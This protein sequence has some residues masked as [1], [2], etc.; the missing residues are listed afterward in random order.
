MSTASR[1]SAQARPRRR[2]SSRPDGRRRGRARPDRL[3]AV[4][5]PR[6]P[7]SGAACVSG[8]APACCARCSR[9]V[10][11]SATRFGRRPVSDAGGG[12]AADPRWSRWSCASC[13]WSWPSSSRPSCS[14]LAFDDLDWAEVGRAL[15]SLDD[16]EIIALSSDVAGVDRRPGSADVLAGP[17]PPGAS[18]RRRLSRPGG[19]GVGR[20]PD[21]ATSRCA[22]GC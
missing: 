4:D 1:R 5:T 2:P 19:G 16:A 8:A 9:S 21:R 13:S 17:R 3:D 10:P 6:R 22:T 12:R 15:R 7:T 14:A 20:C 18:R 11:A